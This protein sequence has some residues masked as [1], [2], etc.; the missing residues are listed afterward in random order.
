MSKPLL[1]S[2]IHFRKVVHARQKHID[3]HDLA[4]IASSGFQYR[5]KILD[6]QVGHLA[7]GRGREGQDLAGGCAGDLSRAV[8]CAGGGDCLGLRGRGGVLAL[9]G[10]PGEWEGWG[11]AVEGS[12]T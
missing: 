10:R 8:D 6:A 2:P 1:I 5:G 7:Y 4:D 9:G 11:G 3:F 12:S